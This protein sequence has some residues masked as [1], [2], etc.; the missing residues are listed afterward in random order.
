MRPASTPRA[1]TRRGTSTSRRA[2]A[3]A[4]AAAGGLTVANRGG[5]AAMLASDR[6]TFVAAPSVSGVSPATGPTTGGTDVTIAGANL[7]GATAVRFGGIG[8]GFVVN[9]DGTITATAP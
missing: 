5:A 9:G 7:A 1:G 6:F 3:A 4:A 2:A 8:A